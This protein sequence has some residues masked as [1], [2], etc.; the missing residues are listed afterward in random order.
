MALIWNS[1]VQKVTNI[2]VFSFTI[3]GVRNVKQKP[4]IGVFFSSSGLPG[5]SIYLLISF[6]QPRNQWETLHHDLKLQDVFGMCS[7]HIS[8]VYLSCF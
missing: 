3:S 5:N 7:S 2:L 4:S 6:L 1:S 8:L